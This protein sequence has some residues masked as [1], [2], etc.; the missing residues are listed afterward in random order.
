MTENGISNGIPIVANGT[1]TFNNSTGNA[2]HWSQLI[3]SGLQGTGIM[4]TDSANQLLY[5]FDSM[6]GEFTG[7]LYASTSVPVIE[8]DPVT[9]A[10]SVSFTSPLDLTWYGAVATFNGA[11]P[12]CA[13]NGNSG[14]WPIVEQ[15]PSVNIVPV[16]SGAP[17]IDVSPPADPVGTSVTVSGGGFI[18]NSPI[19]I[20]YNGNT[21][22]T[23]TSTTYGTIPSGT[24]FVIPSSS[25]GSY[26]ISAID[27]S[28]N[29][30]SAN[31]TVTLYPMETI[32]FQLSG[33]SSDVGSTSIITID[34][35]QYPFSTH[36]ILFSWEAGTTH[37]ISASST[38]A[39]GTGK[40]YIWASWSDGGAQTHNYT[41][42]TSSAT[43]SATYTTQYQVTFNYQVSGGGS[44]T[45]PSVTYYQSGSQLSTTAG[46]SATV[47][48]DSGSTYTYTNNPLTGSGA[49]ERWYASSSI[50]G[51]ISSSLTINPAYYHQYLMTLSYSVSGGGS[52]TAPTLTS[53]QFG[54]AYTPTLTGSATGYWLDNGAS[55]SV[56]NPL[57]GS[58]GTERWYTGQ[59]ASGTV[60]ATTTIAFVYNHQYQVTFDASS[61]V[62]G[63]SS[64]TIVTVAGTSYNYAQL[65]YTNWFNAGSLTYS[66]SSP[67]GSSSNSTTGYF[68]SSTSG[69]GQTLQS[70][71][72]TVSGTGTVTATY[73][74]QLLPTF[75]ID[76]N[77]IGYGSI[78][79]SG[80]SPITTTSMTA[81]TNELIMIVITQGNSGS[82]SIRTFALTDSF[83]S[84]LTYT[85]KGSTVSSGSNAE[86]ISVYYAVTDSSHTGSFTITVTP[87]S[88]N[89]NFDVLV[90]GITGANTASPFDSNAVLPRT[91]SNTGTSTPTVTGIS[92]SNANDMI[93]AFEGQLSSTTQ[94]A[95]SPFQ[96]I[97]SLLRNSNG[98]G[99]NVQYEIV[100]Q[101]QTNIS[102]QFGQSVSNWVMVVNAVKRAW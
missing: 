54:G 30:A 41:V 50:S 12:I 29:S 2:H 96:S 39:A 11:N 98:E 23:T 77:C 97:A 3:N 24:T 85:Q 45:A 33:I 90:F 73:T 44:P 28:S 4:F 26:T 25:P 7:A 62:K 43:V 51:T 70:N 59:S 72:F 68:W 82:S 65:P 6:A 9:S 81:Q 47:W 76:A 13:N 102:A 95:G 5:A 91:N 84:H 99:C 80:A 89:R 52:P 55:W 74:N 100:T 60:S 87:S 83:S 36:P 42:P 20:T 49:S 94:T 56:A 61:N 19:T 75:G 79:S 18:P 69:L 67:I 88:Y 27:T 32:A 58:S 22:A 64:T 57:G 63:D 31:F 35:I 15:P 17:W 86:A 92:T 10:G 71:T 16:S 1:G 101:T 53:T 38:V 8:L 37:T 66:Y 48:V 78:S 14:L 34:S 40:Q 21:V 93:L 46:P